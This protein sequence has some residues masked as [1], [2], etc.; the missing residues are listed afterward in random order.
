MHSFRKEWPESAARFGA[1]LPTTIN[2][3][4]CVPSFVN[5]LGQTI[6]FTAKHEEL[7]AAGRNFE[8]SGGAVKSTKLE[9]FFQVK[10]HWDAAV[11]SLGKGKEK[12]VCC[13]FSDSQ[14]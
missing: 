11:E 2:A 13:C 6:A 4:I 14:I 10:K 3:Q 7:L 5:K 1:K 12:E 8:H 9:E